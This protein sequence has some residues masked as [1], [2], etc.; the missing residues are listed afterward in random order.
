MLD[1]MEL[2]RESPLG[3][4]PDDRTERGKHSRHVIN[5][6]YV[7]EG[8]SYTKTLAIRDTEAHELSWIMCPIW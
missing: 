5:V 1:F 3:P 7:D 2:V 8:K 6:R 4:E